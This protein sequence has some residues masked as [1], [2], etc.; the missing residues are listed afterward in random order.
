MARKRSWGLLCGV[1][2]ALL[3][4]APVSY[5][6]SPQP[7]QVSVDV[8]VYGATPQGVTAAAAAAYRGLRV[9]LADPTSFVGGAFAQS[10]LD[11]LDL[12]WDSSGAL[13]YGGLVQEFVRRLGSFDGVDVRRAGR[14]L[15][16]LLHTSGVQVKLG[17]RL[18]EVEV[19]HNRVTAV[20]MA[21]PEGRARIS[22]EAVVDATDVAQLAAAAG[23]RFTVGREDTGLDRRSMAAGLVLRLRGLSWTQVSVAACPSRPCPD[24]SGRGPY[25]VWGFNGLLTR[26]VP[27]DPS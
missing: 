5:A 15:R 11:T 3:A 26:Y 4:A 8:L 19:S 25:L 20:V 10:W 23:V 18:E 17:W 16:E 24:G 22:A 1:A 12:S 13:L 27:S 21:T 14:I 6:Q 7:R 9:V 2:A